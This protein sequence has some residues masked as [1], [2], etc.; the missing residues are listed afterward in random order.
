MSRQ[1]PPAWFWW[2]SLLA[3]MGALWI[4]QPSA[5]P[6]KW[7]GILLMQAANLC[8]AAGQIAWRRIRS[9]D[10]HSRD[11]DGYALLYLGGVLAALPF[12]L[13]GKPLQ[14]LA[15]LSG[16]QWAALIYLGTVASGLGFFLWNAGAARVN[17]ATLAVFNNLKIPVAILISI[18]VF[19]EPAHLGSLIPGL[20]VLLI[21]LGW[22]ERASRKTVTRNS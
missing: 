19:N 6:G 21:A 4:F 14:E 17:P 12:A 1:L 18:T 20:A 11:S 7:P 2:T 3:V 16:S 10:P 15:Q 5:L 13:A 8:F 22:A 9:G